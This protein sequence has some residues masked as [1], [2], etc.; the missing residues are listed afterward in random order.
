MCAG[1]LWEESPHQFV[2][3]VT[4]GWSLLRIML[5]A[6]KDHLKPTQRKYNWIGQNSG[7]A[8]Y[9]YINI[10]LVITEI[11]LRLVKHLSCLRHGL[12]ATETQS[13]LRGTLIKLL[14]SIV[15]TG[16]IATIH[17]YIAL[18]TTVGLYEGCGLC[19]ISSKIVLLAPAH[20]GYSA[21][22][23]G[24]DCAILSSTLTLL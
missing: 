17:T 8:M 21:I 4:E 10:V 6:V 2:L 13:K 23:D 20:P 14:I 9:M 18:A 1:K 11:L 22:R 24:N 19:K 5:C 12:Q 16:Y 3:K 15:F 7:A